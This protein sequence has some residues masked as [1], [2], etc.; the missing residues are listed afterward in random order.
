MLFTA[1]GW[2]DVLLTL[3][4]QHFGRFFRSGFYSLRVLPPGD[5]LAAER[6]AGRLLLPSSRF[7]RELVKTM[8]Q[9]MNPNECRT[10]SHGYRPG[11]RWTRQGA[12]PTSRTTT[13]G[14]F[15]S[16]SLSQGRRG[17]VPSGL[18][19]RDAGNRR[20]AG[21]QLSRR[22]G[23]PREQR[24]YHLQPALHDAGAVRRG[25][26]NI[27]AVLLTS[28]G[29]RHVETRRQAICNITSIH[30]VRRTRTFGL[31]RTKGAI[32][33]TPARW[34][35][36]WRTRAFASTP[37]RPVVTVENYSKAILTSMKRRRARSPTK[38]PGGRP[39]KVEIAKLAVFLLR[40]RGLHRWPDDRTGTTAR[41]R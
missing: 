14:A 32:I 15:G 39:R 20:P 22:R 37:S 30:G 31:C 36:N 40:S 21:H 3:D 34:R 23:L 35:W 13:R 19:R 6:K 28:R 29:G 26:T 4:R 17:G 8:N 16:R 33:F 12:T 41:C 2:A 5:F 7:G 25:T 9:T 1:A 27:R 18:Q 10:S 38:S 11:M 24:R